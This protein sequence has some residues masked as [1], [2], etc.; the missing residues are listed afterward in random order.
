MNQKIR[1]QGSY[2]WLRR[3]ISLLL[4]AAIL[5]AALV[6]KTQAATEHN[7]ITGDVS[8]YLVTMHKVFGNDF[9]GMGLVRP[10]LIAIPLK[11][12]ISICGP[13][14][15][16]R[17]VG[18]LI[19][20][21]I[22]IPF[23]LVACRISPPPFA[24][25][26][27]GLFVFTPRYSYMLAWGYITFFGIFFS[28]LSFYFLL[29]TLEHP[30]KR[31]IFFAGLSASLT[32]GFHQVSFVIMLLTM[33]IFLVLLLVS[34]LRDLRQVLSRF[35]SVGLVGAV[36]SIPYVPAYL[37][38]V[39][40]FS[41]AYFSSTTSFGG[42]LYLTSLI[43]FFYGDQKIDLPLL[44][45][46]VVGLAIAW[47]RYKRDACMISALL[48]VP[49][50]VCVSNTD[51]PSRRVMYFSYIPVWM[52]LMLVSASLHAQVSE[53]AERLGRR[54]IRTAM[55]AIVPASLAILLVFVIRRSQVSLAQW[56]RFFATTNESQLE[57]IA[58]IADHVPEGQSLAI[59]PKNFG[60]WTEGLA[61]RNAFEIPAAS[62]YTRQVHETLVAS[63][64]LSGNQ[65]VE[66]GNVRVATNYPYGDKTWMGVA[67][68]ALWPDMHNASYYDLFHLDENSI[69]VHYEDGGEKTRNL[70]EARN[71]FL[72]VLH[73][74]E[75]IRLVWNYRFP[76][77]EVIQTTE[78]KKGDRGISTEWRFLPSSNSVRITGFSLPIFLAVED[79]EIR[80]DGL[81]GADTIVEH[82]RFGKAWIDIYYE[83]PGLVWRTTYQKN[84][85]GERVLQ[86]K[87]EL[88]EDQRS[89]LLYFWLGS[90][91][92]IVETP[93][94]HFELEDLLRDNDV[95]Y[96]AID[97]DPPFPPEEELPFYVLEW[98]DQAAYYVPLYDEDDIKIYEVVLDYPDKPRTAMT[99]YLGGG[100]EFLGWTV[101]GEAHRPGGPLNLFLYWRSQGRID[102]NYKV[103]THLLNER[104]EIVTQHDSQ[105]CLWRCPTSAW[106]EGETV[107]D[108]HPILVS[109]DVQPGE[110]TLAVGMYY[111]PTGE[112]VAAYDDQG[113]RLPHDTIILGNVLL[114][115]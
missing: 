18:L 100:I 7:L 60:M 70:S 88:P 57:A 81:K 37:S 61:T 111:E 43:R 78:L 99:A 24:A 4:V 75:S 19:A 62:A 67:V 77:F 69:V 85:A 56:A 109:R 89:L 92:G 71:R 80:I 58:W 2:R 1:G 112:R 40:V 21:A 17:V 94:N 27:T 28:L 108:L 55:P 74:G 87:F 44:L 63:V 14:V 64:I 53:R 52:L 8:N 36:L 113:R 20:V 59:Y 101:L 10:P 90:N 96:V 106:K 95:R 66:N 30:S 29:A 86:Y 32:A 107:I 51:V 105:P 79:P 23:Y 22:G 11:V 34:H 39:S 72:E 54:L 91:A 73:V 42:I 35:L 84:S 25:L 46:L 12:A 47:H 110:Y 31:N 41:R 45:L 103:F 97:K 68:K 114:E 104:G 83:H 5:L 38:Q 115:K 48:L 26:A 93:V 6:L 76:D 98:F 49:I 50:V 13:L 16:Q 9:M 33:G 15:G 82:Q 3:R 102:E 65:A